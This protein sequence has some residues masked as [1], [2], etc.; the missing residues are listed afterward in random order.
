MQQA[1]AEQQEMQQIKESAMARG[2]FMKAP[3]GKPT[4]LTERQW[5]QVR[6][7]AFKKWFGDWENDPQNASKVVDENGEPLVVYHGTSSA[8]FSTFDSSRNGSRNL[9]GTNTEGI[10]F[11]ASEENAESIA[12]S[13]KKGDI[14]INGE[15]IWKSR[16]PFMNTELISEVVGYKVSTNPVDLMNEEAKDAYDLDV[17]RDYFTKLGSPS[18]VTEVSE[19]FSGVMPVFLNIRDM[20]IKDYQSK[21]LMDTSSKEFD[22]FVHNAKDGGALTNIKDGKMKLSTTYFVKYPN[23]IK[24][25][26]NNNGNFSV[27]NDDIE[28]AIERLPYITNELSEDEKEDIRKQL[29]EKDQAGRSIID[30]RNALYLLD[31]TDKEGIE[32]RSKNQEGFQCLIKVDTSD[33]TQKEKN[34]LINRINNG[35]IKNQRDADLWL[36]GNSEK[37][38]RY[39]S[40]SIVAE[41]RSS[42][43]DY[44]GLSEEALQ[45]ETLG[46][47]SDSYSQE[48]SR[49]DQVRTGFDGTNG[50][51][52]TEVQTFITPA[53]EVYGF[54]DKKGEI[55]LDE[56][57]IRPKAFSPFSLHLPLALCR[58]HLGKLGILYCYSFYKF[59]V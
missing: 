36:R 16:Y 30:G 56:T 29:I 11:T 43:G 26:T 53:G 54:V 7:Q 27:T 19:D 42:N 6:T 51:R 32:N 22:D 52:Y 44:A 34:E 28:M 17:I 35:N 13:S 38:G 23:Q 40:D 1:L 3:N 2:D 25:A 10:Y 45:G 21:N 48:N 49:K 55:Y 41:V 4:N 24:S 46:G 59:A 9:F 12:A 18:E 39:N 50:P 47:R 58:L 20:P 8:K 31:H 14:L 33:L 5:L 37:Q 15:P 57:V